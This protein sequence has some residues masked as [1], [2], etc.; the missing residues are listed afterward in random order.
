MDAPGISNVASY[1]DIEGIKQSPG[2]CILFFTKSKGC[3]GCKA[4]EPVF[5]QLAGDDT[6][7]RVRCYRLDVHELA[8]EKSSESMSEQVTGVPTFIM[9]RDGQQIDRV[10]GADREALT[11][12]FRRTVDPRDTTRPTFRNIRR[13]SA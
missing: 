1:Q 13:F 6:G 4:I 5:Q 12:M 10:V 7:A 3:T 11:N 2:Y 9:Y 8:L